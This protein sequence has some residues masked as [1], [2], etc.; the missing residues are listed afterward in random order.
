MTLEHGPQGIAS[1]H[2]LDR[3]RTG[4]VLSIN[5]SGGGVPKRRVTDA[6]VSKNGLQND[7]HDDK[8]H[9]GGLDRAVV[10]YA[11]ERIR[12]LQTEGHPVD[13]GTAGEN[14]TVEGLDWDLVA[15]GI[16]IRV[17]AEV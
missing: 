3:N 16:R 9:H 13:I 1:R 5:I 2:E 11:L 8:K 14:L 12:G 10:L 6:I 15:P 17:G 4:A 7:A